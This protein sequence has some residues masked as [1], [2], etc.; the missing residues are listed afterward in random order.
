MT[1]P[2]ERIHLLVTTMC[3]RN[4]PHCCNK[5]YDLNKVPYVTDEEL[6][7][8]KMILIT[9][10]EP[11]LFANPNI[12]A[13][14]LKNKYL[15]IEKVIVYT[16]AMELYRYLYKGGMT[17]HIDGFSISI[18]TMEDRLYFEQMALGMRSVFDGKS[19]RVYFFHIQDMPS[20]DNNFVLIKREWQPNFVPA[21]DSIFRKI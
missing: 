8:A 16:N 13:R 15:N 20:K 21:M 6:S 2:N 3:A 14:E 17:N 9:G 4:C 11:F 10:G 7:K 5:Q 12:I 1:D 18:K 19:N